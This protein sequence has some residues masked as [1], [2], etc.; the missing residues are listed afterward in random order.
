MNADAINDIATRHPDAFRRSLW[1]RY[2]V[3]IGILLCIFYTFYCAWF[4]S[5]ASVLEKA[6]W[7]LAGAYLADWVSYETTPAFPNW[8][9]IQIPTG[10]PSRWP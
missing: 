4:F 3:P 7:N 1:K 5:I 6:N 8:D 9:P 2:A 10:W